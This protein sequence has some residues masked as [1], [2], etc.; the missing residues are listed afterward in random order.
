MKQELARAK[1]EEAAKNNKRI[2]SLKASFDV[3]DKDNS[4]SLSADEL[5][6]VLTRPGGGAPMDGQDAV[7]FVTKYDKNKDGKDK[8]KEKGD[9]E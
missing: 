3:F 1:A 9:D 6:A 2:A 5:K 7:E 4:L 8:S